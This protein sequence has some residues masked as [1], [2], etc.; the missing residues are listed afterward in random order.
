VSGIGTA[1]PVGAGSPPTG[2]GDDGAPDLPVG[3]GDLPAGSWP[4]P[5]SR[6]RPWRRRHRVALV[7]LAVVVVV[8]SGA[9]GAFV[10]R[11]DHS[12][13][14][15]LSSSVAIQRFLAAGGARSADPSALQP[16]A[17]VYP[18]AGSGHEHISLPPR[19]QTEGP[20]MPGTI[21]YRSDGCWVWRVDYSDSHWQSATFCPRGG[22]LAEVARAGWYRWSFVALSIADT[23]TFTC[24]PEIAR[25]AVLHAGQAFPFSCT[26]TNDPIRTAPVIVRG[27][28][29]YLG[30][31][32][33]HVGR[34]AVVAMHF[35]ERTT[36]SGGQRGTNVADVW[37]AADDALPLMASWTT[38]VSSPT[39]LGTST[40][41]GH[42]TLRLRSLTPRS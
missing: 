10:Y 11:W 14:V 2:D 35:Q 12:G 18:Y 25:P 30:L 39:F 33:V 27:T 41:T 32:V 20:S 6:R 21:S 37:L 40:L 36:Y 23:A 17:G 22:N 4:G 19:S 26:G 15:P 9:V 28:N 13:P 34:Q 38:S 7:A 31:S 3:V 5:P 29:R 8:L 16:A 42:A 1:V 24:T